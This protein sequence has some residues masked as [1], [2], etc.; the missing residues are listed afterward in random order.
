MVPKPLSAPTGVWIGNLLILNVTVQ[1]LQ[2]LKHST[3]WIHQECLA[4]LTLYKKGRH[5]LQNTWKKYI[6]VR[7]L[8]T[9]K[10]LTLKHLDKYLS[11][12]KH[13][14]KVFLC[15]QISDI[16]FSFEIWTTR[17]I[18]WLDTPTAVKIR[19][20]NWTGCFKKQA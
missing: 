1:K 10:E 20:F 19:I 4:M 12:K 6:E 8:Y 17:Y 9:A 7:S 13:F 16:I 15:F 11:S 14:K 18:L 2:L 3:W 5:I